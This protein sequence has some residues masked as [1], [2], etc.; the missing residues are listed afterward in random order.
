MEHRDRSCVSIIN[1]DLFGKSIE[2]GERLINKFISCY[3]VP[4][5]I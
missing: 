2:F 3:C 5:S 1:T 4:K